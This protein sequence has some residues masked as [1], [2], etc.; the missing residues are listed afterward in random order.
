[1]TVADEYAAIPEVSQY[2]FGKKRLPK[3]IRVFRATRG[4]SIRRGDFVSAD[5]AHAARH[6]RDSSYKIL[7]K[8]VRPDELAVLGSSGQ[9][10]FTEFLY[11]PKRR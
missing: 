11:V 1:V 9:R 3:Q 7:S 5:R 8:L 4:K 10:G 2:Y 6:V